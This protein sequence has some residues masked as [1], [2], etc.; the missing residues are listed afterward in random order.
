MYHSIIIS[1]KNTYTEWGIVPTS[2]PHIVPPEVKT[3]DV[4]LPSSHGV[5]DY[6]D[7][8][9]AE[10]PYG[11][12]K[13]SW[14]FAVK[15]GNLWVDVYS[16]IL[17]YLH[18]IKHTVILEDDPGYLYTGRLKVND[19]QSEER[20]VEASDDTEWQWNDLFQ[21]VVR[22][23]RFTVSG[24]KYRNLIN[25]GKRPAIP[26]FTCS[27]PVSVLYQGNTYDL[28]TGKNYNANLALLPGDNEMLFTGNAE[29][30]AS[31]REVSL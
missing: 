18:G 22:Y 17:N 7:L 13:G 16:S 2:R 5:L 19:W 6:T 12:R 30:T 21:D 28:V 29:V 4:D 27:A 24:S 9:L 14:E 20:Y 31:Y 10:T 11:Q 3:S 15:P 26:T 23:G 8:L 25:R 1:G